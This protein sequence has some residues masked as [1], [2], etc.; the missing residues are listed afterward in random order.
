MIP[1]LVLSFFAAACLF[2]GIAAL[3]ERDAVGSRL[4]SLRDGELGPARERP[5]DDA[6]IL[7]TEPT[8]WG[9]RVLAGLAGRDL[10]PSSPA[11]SKVRRRLLEAGYRRPSAL[12]TYLGSRVALAAGLGLLA[13]NASVARDLD[14]TRLGAL[15]AFA[16]GCGLVLPSFLLDRR[17]A[18]RQQ[19]I[20]NALPDAL[21]LLVVCIEAG[22]ALS[23]AISRVA[24]QYAA[25]NPELAEEFELV[26]LESQAGKSN[27]EALRGLAERT[28]LA[29][30]SSMVA[31]LVQTERFG[32]SVA[33]ALRVHAQSMRRHRMQVAEE[34]A[35]K[36][37]LKM[38]FPAA[39]FIFPATLMVIAGPGVIR[40]MTTLSSG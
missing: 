16:A 30:V 21:D 2:L 26:A 3:L 29:E 11:L 17:I 4:A 10:D 35:A 34:A 23:A 27:V 1:V 25:S 24:F 37:P 15:V 38:L 28:G 13:F 19:S 40:L 31:M 9:A 8:G 22:L 12:R 5:D 36:A 20:Q 18:R 32:T 7:V 14:P 39:L 33:D 6:G